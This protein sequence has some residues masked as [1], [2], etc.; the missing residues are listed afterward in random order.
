MNKQYLAHH[1]VKGQKWGVRR[2]IDENGNLTDAG[3][4]RYS[5][6]RGV[7][8]YLYDTNTNRQKYVRNKS[9][10]RA[11]INGGIVGL[12][13]IKYFRDHHNPNTTTTRS[14]LAAAYTYVAASAA[15]A[16]GIK[17][18]QQ[19]NLNTRRQIRDLENHASMSDINRAVNYLNSQNVTIRRDP[20]EDKTALRRT[21]DEYRG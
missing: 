19:K 3:K 13:T 16:A 17:Y 2:Y 15:T 6:K 1:G 11:V 9:I 8:K 5:G 10:R 4:K 14:A 12:G 21:Y 18:L 20:R 7:G